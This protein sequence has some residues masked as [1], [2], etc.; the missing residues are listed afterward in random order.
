MEPPKALHTPLS[1]EVLAVLHAG[2]RCTISGSVYTARDAAHRRLVELLEAG[3]PLPFPLDGAVIYYAGPTPAPPG[4]VIGSIGPTT[5]LRMDRYT[6]PL[7]ARGLKGMI[8]KGPRGTEVR[9]ALQEHK[10]VYFAA[11][12]GAAA[13]TAQAVVSAE[14]IAFAELG[15]EAIR[16][17]E[18]RN[19]PVVVINDVFGGDFYEA[20]IKKFS[21][22]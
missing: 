11:I 16:R 19:L 3:K 10:A 1:D 14:M 7:L 5:S 17:L 4:R 18:V 6:P 12:S 15:P 22:G 20:G 21:I 9:D 8:G 2:D 13:L